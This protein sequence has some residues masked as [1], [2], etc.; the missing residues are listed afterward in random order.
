MNLPYVIDNREHTL[1]D[2][3]NHLLRHDDVHALDVATAYFNIGG[4]DLLRESLDGLDS[5]RLLLGAE[6]GSGDDIGLQVRRDLNAAPFDEE[7][8][9]LV[10]T[11]IRYL[12]RESVLVRLYRGGFLHAKAYL[13][14][15]DRAR[16]D[17]FTPVAGIVG[18]SNF[19]RAGLTTNQELN[20]THKVILSPGE[21]EDAPAAAAVRPLLPNAEMPAIP[22]PNASPLDTSTRQAIKSEVGARAILELLDWYEARWGESQPYKDELIALLN[23][24]KFGDYEYTPCHIYLKTLYEY[25]KDEL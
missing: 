4:Y 3:L 19:T 24:S 6:P 14:F 5:F 2:V 7:T 16:G 8:S 20:L 22:Q 18:S 17:R 13:A 9:H 1:A 23:E 10:E 12:R 25:F 21:V 11:L 15:A